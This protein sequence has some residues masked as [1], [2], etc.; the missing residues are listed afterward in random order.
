MMVNYAFQY[1]GKWA[2]QHCIVLFLLD[3]CVRLD[4]FYQ[5]PVLVAI[6]PS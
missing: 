6:V 1:S 3:P 2:L 5:L 4:P